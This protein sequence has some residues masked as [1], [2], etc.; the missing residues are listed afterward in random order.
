MTLASLAEK[1]NVESSY[2]SRMFKQEMGKNLMLYIAEKRI[3]KA[4]EYMKDPNIN[5]T[6][7]AFL[8]G[9]DDYTYFSRVFKKITGKSP[10][11]YR[12]GCL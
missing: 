2:F 5:L 12:S 9:Y 10:R 7:I 4:R 1:Y 6:E 8:I 11:E 3:E